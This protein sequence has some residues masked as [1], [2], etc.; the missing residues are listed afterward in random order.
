VPDDPEQLALDLADANLR[1]DRLARAIA[2]KDAAEARVRELEAALRQAKRQ[3]KEA[4]WNL[5]L[6]L[7]GE[8]RKKE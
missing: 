8:R 4:G 2:A 3:C 7:S 6:A 5:T 1:L